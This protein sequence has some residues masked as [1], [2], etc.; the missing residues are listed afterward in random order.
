VVEARADTT[1]NLEALRVWVD[2]LHRS[3]VEVAAT[4]TS[5]A[6]NMDRPVVEDLVLLLANSLVEATATT[7]SNTL[8]TTI[9]DLREV[10]ADL[11]AWPAHSWEAAARLTTT[12]LADSTDRTRTRATVEAAVLTVAATSSNMDLTKATV[13]A[14][15]EASSAASWAETSTTVAL[16]DMATRQEEAPAA[17]TL[18]LRHPAHTSLRDSRTTA[19]LV[20]DT[21]ALTAAL[22]HQVLTSPRDSQTTAS[23][24][25]DTAPTVVQRL[26]ALHRNPAPTTRL[27]T[28]LMD[29]NPTVDHNKADLEDISSPAP[30]VDL[31]SSMAVLTKAATLV[32]EVITSN[33]EATASPKVDTVDSRPLLEATEAV[34]TN[35]MATAATEDDLCRAFLLDIET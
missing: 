27:E 25:K 13:A 30:T 17:P 24:A 3:L 19:N 32:L 20:K 8:A 26:K 10:L 5:M 34:D 11:Q 4:T 22:R 31:L 12:S 15:A 2:L 6:T 29:N 14:V 33:R 35:S 21:V 18:A 1:T 16:A 23:L 28:N 7:T 9:M